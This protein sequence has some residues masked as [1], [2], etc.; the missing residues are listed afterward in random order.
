LKDTRWQVLVL[1]VN[2]AD[3]PGFGALR[4][5]ARKPKPNLLS[6]DLIELLKKLPET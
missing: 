4:L 5:L 3:D 6:L 1:W 2:I